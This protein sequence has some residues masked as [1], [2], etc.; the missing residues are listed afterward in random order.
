MSSLGR[1]FRL[2][3]GV[4]DKLAREAEVTAACHQAG[5]ALA[6]AI[7][8]QGHTVGDTS[9]DGATQQIPLPV[10][11]LD[12]HDGEGVVVII[13]HPAG[14]AEQAKNGVFTKAAS[15]VGMRVR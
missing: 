8:A 1:A 12:D 2:G 9:P 11:V 13:D 3:P 15:Q 6:D 5:E 4:L 7:R 10:E 14:A